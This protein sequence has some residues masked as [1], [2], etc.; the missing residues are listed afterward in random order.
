MSR[1]I[2]RI[3][4]IYRREGVLSQE[5]HGEIKLIFVDGFSFFFLVHN[6]MWPAMRYSVGTS[7]EV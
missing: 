5:T 4:F 3:V 6:S 7:I 2:T 1:F